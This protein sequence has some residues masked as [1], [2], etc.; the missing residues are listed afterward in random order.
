MKEKAEQSSDKTYTATEVAKAYNVTTQTIY[1]WIRRGKILR[2]DW[3]YKTAPDG[4]KGAL[5]FYRTVFNK[6]KKKRSPG[7]QQAENNVV[8]KLLDERLK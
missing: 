8:K 5:V 2:R 3:D 1:N 7:R 6:L 4:S